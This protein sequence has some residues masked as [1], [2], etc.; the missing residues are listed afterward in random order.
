LR[1]RKEDI[2]MLAQYF[3]DWYASKMEKKIWRIDKKTLDLFQS[4][5]WPGNIRELQNVIE[6]SVILC[7]TEEFSVEE[8][9]IVWEAYQT[10]PTG[11][12]PSDKLLK[13]KKEII[14]AA[15][16]GSR[17]QVSG[18][19]GAAAKLGIPHS[20]H[21]SGIADQISQDQQTSLQTP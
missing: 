6:R 11:Q 3:I 21:H 8:S 13:Q 12:S 10:Q 15:L 20:A 18:P 5:P 14:E 4:Y 17:G 2:P 19:A 16:A 9:W 7:E 1:E